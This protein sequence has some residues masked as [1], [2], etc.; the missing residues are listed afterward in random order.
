MFVTGLIRMRR[1]SGIRISLKKK[2]HNKLKGT[3]QILPN[4][5]GNEPTCSKLISSFLSTSQ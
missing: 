3:V 4:A 5:E 1:T 2:L